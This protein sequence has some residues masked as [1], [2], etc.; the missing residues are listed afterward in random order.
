MA[1]NPPKLG[2]R[3]DGAASSHHR[4]AIHIAIA[5]VRATMKLH[6]GQGIGFVADNKTDVGLVTHPIGIV[7]PFIQSP[8]YPGDVFYMFLYPNTITSLRHD[9][10]HPAFADKTRDGSEP[11]RDYV[12]QA[13]DEA[14]VREPRWNAAAYQTLQAFA[15]EAG[16][17]VE[18]LVD[19][20]TAYQ[21]TGGDHHYAFGFD[22]PDCFWDRQAEFWEAWEAYTG[23]KVTVD[24]QPFSCAC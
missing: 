2:D 5:P 9:W 17:D 21:L 16:M 13:R 11:T 12:D 19:H 24:G 18:T 14:A 8:I 4:D 23:R 1:S 22:T 6:P 15:D 3:L 10:T 7:D 20:A